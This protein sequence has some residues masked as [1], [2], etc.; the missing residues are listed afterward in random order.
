MPISKE[1]MVRV[2]EEKMREER[3]ETE[4]II[5]LVVSRLVMIIDTALLTHMAVYKQGDKITLKSSGFQKF[6]WCQ[7][8][9]NYD[10]VCRKLSRVY[11]NCG[12]IVYI[13]RDNERIVLH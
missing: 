13:D 5:R 6:L 9:S 10:E 8:G 11:G 2:C 12:W 7:S 1:Q 4:T 3:G